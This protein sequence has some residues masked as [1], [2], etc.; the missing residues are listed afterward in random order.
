MAYKYVLQ[1]KRGKLV[2]GVPR[3]KVTSDAMP[4]GKRLEATKKTVA[5][6][7]GL[8]TK[9]AADPGVLSRKKVSLKELVVFSRQFSVLYA[10]GI[11]L[12]RALET[13]S[14]Q[15]GNPSFKSAV[16]EVG[17]SVEAGSSLADAMVKFPKVFPWLY[18]TMVRAGET[19]GILD[20]VLEGMAYQYEKDLDLREKIIS[21]FSYPVVVLIAAMGILA[22]L[23]LYVIP[24][25]ERIYLSMNVPLPGPTVFVL[26]V[27][28]IVRTYW[29]MFP[30][31]GAGA[32]FGFR[33]FVSTERGR[34]L[35]DRFKL[36]FPIF[37]PIIH[38]ASITRFCRVLSAAVGAGVSMVTALSMVADVAGNVIVAES[39]R[40]MIEKV[41][42]GEAIGAQMGRNPIFPPMLVQMVSVGEE[43]G[44]SEK[45]LGKAA[46]FYEMEIDHSV[47]RLS[48]ALEPVMM[49]IIG[50]IVAVI[51]FALYMPLFNLGKAL[52]GGKG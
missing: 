48:S 45:M 10:A 4:L 18:V 30:F 29:W 12:P 38:K 5:K 34:I 14:E 13:L 21:A 40:A 52:S 25:F 1:D 35:F 46:D 31:L 9:T 36:M 6:S 50:G 8:P 41:Q 32:F 3:V 7:L 37:G 44:E 2:R 16:R 20:N 15:V 11:S 19:A 47:K 27:S 23:I 49:G 24:I 42:E 33:S 17:K 28:K 26:S 39:I 22:F 43:T 51:A